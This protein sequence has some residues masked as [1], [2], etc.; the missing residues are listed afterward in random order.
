M[1]YM[2]GTP[3]LFYRWKQGCYFA[4]DLRLAQSFP[5][6]FVP[7]LQ[8]YILSARSVSCCHPGSLSAGVSKEHPTSPCPQHGKRRPEM[9]WSLSQPS[10]SH[11]PPSHFLICSLCFLTNRTLSHQYLCPIHL[12]WPSDFALF[13]SVFEI[14]PSLCLSFENTVFLTWL[15]WDSLDDRDTACLVLKKK[16]TT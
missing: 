13:F 1:S 5:C 8:L 11:P 16:P 9:S 14:L 12:F 2:Q 15:S 6:L 4:V 10:H 3:Y 7:C